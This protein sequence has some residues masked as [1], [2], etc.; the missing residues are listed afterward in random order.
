MLI[1]D[2]FPTRQKA[3]DFVAYVKDK[4]NL[5]AQVYDSQKEANKVDIFPWAL[6]APIVLVERTL[7]A[8]D[9]E[10]ENIEILIETD[11][12]KFGGTFAGT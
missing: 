5:W 11:V 4:F 1:F 12:D 3:E 2:R 10:G 7:L 9:S 8:C 6:D